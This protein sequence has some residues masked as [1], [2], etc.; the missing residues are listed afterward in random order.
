MKLYYVPFDE[1][2]KHTDISDLVN[3]YKINALYMIQQARGGHIGSAFSSAEIMVNLYYNILGPKD[4]FFSS[5]GHDVAMQ[6]A[7]LQ[8]M[9]KLPFDTIHTFRQPGGLP[10]HPD[11]N[12]TPQLHTNTGSLG[13]GISKARGMIYANRLNGIDARVFV[14]CGDG[15]MEEGQ[16]W[17]AIRNAVKDGLH[18]LRII[19]D[20]NGY[21][22]DGNCLNNDSDLF[23]MLYPVGISI[24]NTSDI[25]KYPFQ[26][27]DKPAAFIVNTKKGA[28]VSFMEDCEGDLYPY[29]SGDL[30]EEEY[31]MAFSELWYELAGPIPLNEAVLACILST[32][33][34]HP[35]FMPSAESPTKAECKVVA[36][37]RNTRPKNMNNLVNDYSHDLVEVGFKNHDVVVLNADLIKDTGCYA[38]AKYFPDRFIEC[39]I[40]EQDMVSTAGGLALKGRIPIVH[41]FAQFLSRRANEQIYNNCTEGKQIIYVGTLAGKL[42]FGPGESH[43]CNEDIALM[44]TM[45]NM[46]ILT[47]T[48]KDQLKAAMYWAIYENKKAT[49]I[50]INAWPVIEEMIE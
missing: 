2:Q 30:S 4:I 49:Y 3:I 21:S 10:G 29:H 31:K 17:E 24:N 41:S 47:P 19:I 48:S 40:S 50:R 15:E 39:G 44:K 45:P 35:E 25:S 16:N 6:Y 18:E 42:P 9:G 36:V 33:D 14:L 26:N 20:Y 12:T 13:M 43:E 34:N 28:G 32:D 7:I 1:I 22:S 23:N 8:G 5:K 46:T 27:K 37:D 38:F 11:I